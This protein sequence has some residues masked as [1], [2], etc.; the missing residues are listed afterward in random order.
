MGTQSPLL[1]AGSANRALAASVATH[2]GLPLAPVTIERLPDRELH[3]E[4]HESPRHRDVFLLQPTSQPADE[5]LFELLSLADA[6]MRGGAAR[7]TAVIP[8]FGYARQD[9]RAKGLE[10]VSAR[11]VA[12]LMVAAGVQRV[13]TLDLHTDAIEGFFTLPVERLTAV[14]LLAEAIKAVRPD[15]GVVVSPD[16][17]AAK[18]AERYAGLLDL[19]AAFVHKTRT[20]PEAVAVSR[21]TGEVRNRTPII[22]DDMIST[23]G[24]IEAAIWAVAA[25]G[26]ECEGII[27]AA[28]HGLFVGACVNRLKQLE[29]KHLF[30]TD[31]VHSRL[32]AELPL[33]TVTVAGLLAEAI[34]SL[35]IAA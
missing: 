8:Y 24:T 23:G 25:A 21:I 3:V 12:D 29:I 32:T 31:S 30:V 10:A 22:I 5:H 19:P 35:T 1:V 14:P 2:L 11:L 15:N 20:G 13:V 9:R 34:R 4:L 17:G 28:T 27:V 33:E 7:I 6:C 26:A 16:L 18:L